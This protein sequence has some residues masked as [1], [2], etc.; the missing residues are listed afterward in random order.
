MAVGDDALQGG[1]RLFE[2][3]VGGGEPAQ[4]GIAVGDD[5]SQRLVDLVGDGCRHLAHRRHLHDAREVDPRLAQRI[6]GTPALLRGAQRGHVVREIS[7]EIA[8]QPRHCMGEARR[9]LGIEFD[10]ALVERAALRGIETERAAKIDIAGVMAVS[11]QRNRDA[12][13]EAV[14]DR[15]GPPWRSGRVG[16]DVVDATGLPGP[17]RDPGRPVPV[18]VCPGNPHLLEEVDPV[19]GARDRPHGL[20][21]VVL[22]IADPC[23]AQLVAADENLANRLQQLLFAAGLKEHPVAA[24]E[25]SLSA[26]EPDG[27]RMLLPGIIVRHR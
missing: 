1:A 7:R 3:G 2:V 22:A 26:A 18:I 4:A 9:Q 27:A 6:F 25:R 15:R 20:V 24:I 21:G 14:R 5:R 10:R 12:G 16:L 11:H 19:P 13:I 17:R 23:Q 8:A